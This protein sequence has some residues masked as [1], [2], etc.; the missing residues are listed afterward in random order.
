MLT[1]IT[2]AAMATEF[3]VILAEDDAHRVEDAVEALEMLDQ[4]EADLTVYQPGSEIARV[5]ASAFEKP[6][7]VSE[8][9]FELL[10]RSIQWN[11]RTEGAFD[12]T[13]GPLVRAWGFTE[14]RGRKPTDEEIELACRRVGSQ[15]LA[16]FPEKRQ[17]QFERAGMEI[18]LGAIGKGFALDRLSARLLDGGVENFLLH[19]G[20]SSVLARGRQSGE[21]EGWLVGIAHPTKENTRLAGIRLQNEALSTSG[22]GKQFFHFRG[23]R[24]GHVIDPRTGYP[25]GD[26]LSLTAVAENAT[27]AEACSTG[28]FVEGLEKIQ[29]AATTDATLPRMLGTRPLQRQNDVRVISFAEFDWVDKPRGS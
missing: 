15:H 29:T 20:A 24:F 9:T 14:R 13:A 25:A 11:R 8:A 21:L 6:V 23:K 16:L 22:S 4:I 5:N 18:N 1:T 3:A 19:G 28:Y 2:H 12:V 17:V 7:T 26:L 10:Q 27:D